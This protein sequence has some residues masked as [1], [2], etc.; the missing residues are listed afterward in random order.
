MQSSKTKHL[1]NDCHTASASLQSCQ[2]HFNKL[3]T[4]AA[5]TICPAPPASVGAKALPS[6]PR[7]QTATRSD[8]RNRRQTASSLIM[9]PPPIRGGAWANSVA[10]L[11]NF[12]CCNVLFQNRY[13]LIS[14]LFHKNSF[15]L[16]LREEQ[17]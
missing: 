4:R 13:I 10:S 5:A 8:V 14:I 6:L 2:S 12:K 1:H 15:K 11:F 16:L 9:P 17:F 3:Y 7:L